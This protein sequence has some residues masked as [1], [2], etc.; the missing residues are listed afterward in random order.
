MGRDGASCKFDLPDGLSEI[1]L[2]MGLDRA[3]Q[4]EPLQQISFLAQRLF[5]DF[6][7]QGS[8]K[9]FAGGLNRAITD[10]PVGQNQQAPSCD[11][12]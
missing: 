4:L 3:N 5:A 1:F 8:E 6:T 9:C 12:D 7:R 2:Q 10:L 11:K